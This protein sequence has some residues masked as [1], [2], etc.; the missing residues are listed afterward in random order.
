MNIQEIEGITYQAEEVDIES[1]INCVARYDKELCRKL[2]Y[3]VTQNQD[4]DG[5]YYIWKEKE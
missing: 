1:C 5:K 2:P 3:C 4:G